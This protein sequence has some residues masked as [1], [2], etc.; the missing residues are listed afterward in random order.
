MRVLSSPG[1]TG[2]TGPK[3]KERES[4]GHRLIIL[5]KEEHAMKHIDASERNEDLDVPDRRSSYR[6]R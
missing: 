2:P 5:S 3:Q 1:W 6:A 4:S